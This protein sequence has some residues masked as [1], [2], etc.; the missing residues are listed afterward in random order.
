MGYAPPMS[1]DHPYPP[2]VACGSTSFDSFPNVGLAVHQQ[3][4]VRSSMGRRE[5]GTWWH[6]LVVCSDCGR[7]D[8]YT[9][10][11]AELRTIVP[12][13]TRFRAVPS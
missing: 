12:N 13:A 11:T 8:V 9:T 2:C 5:V 10:N 1:T 7:T 6:T 3:V 4:P